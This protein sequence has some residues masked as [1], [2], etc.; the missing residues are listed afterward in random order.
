MKGDK[1]NLSFLCGCNFSSFSPLFSL[2]RLHYISENI[3]CQ[4]YFMFYTFIF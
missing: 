3:M 1:K 4:V 2:E